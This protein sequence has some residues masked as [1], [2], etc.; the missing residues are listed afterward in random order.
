M[1]FHLAVVALDFI[2]TVVSTVFVFSC[3]VGIAQYN[4][5]IPQR[6]PLEPNASSLMQ[7]LDASPWIE[8]TH[9]NT[10]SWNPFALILIFEWITLAF[11]TCYLVDAWR[12]WG[13]FAYA[14]D[15][16]GAVFFIC[17]TIFTRDHICI[18]MICTATFSFIACAVIL[19]WY[20]TVRK[21]IAAASTAF[22]IRTQVTVASNRV[23]Q[24]PKR[25]SEWKMRPARLS[26]EA[27][28]NEKIEGK[29]DNIIAVE[30]KVFFRYAEYCITAPLLF[31]A[32]M[33]MLVQDAP[34]WL[35]L[36]GY[37]LIMACNM[38]GML[39]HAQY[40]YTKTKDKAVTPSSWLKWLFELPMV[41][42]Y[43]DERW[44]TYSYLNAAW[45]SLLVP[46]GGLIYAIRDYLF[47]G[48]LPWV[49]QAMIFNLM[50]SFSLFGILPTITYTTGWQWNNLAYILD[51]LNVVSKLFI[52]IFVMIG[53]YTSPAG[54][55]PCNN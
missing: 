42:P 36:N 13:K 47:W 7:Y 37:W 28:Y 8:D 52:P 2:A 29:I 50:I 45:I 44:I 23:W 12:Y 15:A 49:V 1:Y 16:I 18:A 20:N 10:H 17:W 25:L 55:M 4:A 11:A 51:V 31:L 32:I 5:V 24:M 39:I 6:L 46:F 40:A 3:N 34:A 9:F 38:W 22:R 14:F 19:W 33:C 54:F 27:T 21:N 35:F 26:G 30:S 48:G 41:L 53:L 43:R